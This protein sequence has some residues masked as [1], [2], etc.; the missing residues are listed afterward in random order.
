M[1]RRSHILSHKVGLSNLV[2]QIH[3]LV[4]EKPFTAPS[5]L[6]S[7]ILLCT[8]TAVPATCF[9][10]GPITATVAIRPR[11]WPNNLFFPPTF[12]TI[13][14][15]ERC[16]SRLGSVDSMHIKAPHPASPVP[17]LS[18]PSHAFIPSYD[19]RAEFVPLSVRSGLQG[20]AIRSLHR[21]GT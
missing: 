20:P 16:D 18:S 19:P 15:S 13:S 11:R 8:S 1:G 7:Q 2:L 12:V 21:P 10:V 9:N 17:S 3:S 4:P 6:P 14:V 5:P